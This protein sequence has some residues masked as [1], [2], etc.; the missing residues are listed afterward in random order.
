MPSL[1]VADDYDEVDDT[2]TG[3]GAK[4]ALAFDQLDE[5]DLL[6][7]IC[8]NNPDACRDKLLQIVHDEP[9]TEVQKLADVLATIPGEFET[10]PTKDK[11]EMVIGTLLTHS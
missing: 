3:T 8:G 11:D 2:S 10:L 1:L 5:L 4:E 6:L 9:F 7:E